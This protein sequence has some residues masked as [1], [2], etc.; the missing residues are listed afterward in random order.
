VI[1]LNAADFA[2]EFPQSHELLGK[3]RFAAVC[4]LSYF[5]GMVCPGLHSMF[6]SLRFDLKDPSQGNGSLA[7]VV[8]RYDRRVGLFEISFHGCIEGALKAFIRPPS[9]LQPSLAEL[10]RHVVAE[11]FRGSRSLIIGGSRGLGEITAK[12]LAAGGGDVIV[13]YASGAEDARMVCDEINSAGK[14][15]C[16]TVKFDLTVDTP[17]SM[18]VDCST[19][20]A[21]Y[22][23]ATPRIFRKKAATFMPSLFQ[24]FSTFYVEKFHEL[25]AHLQAAAGT[26]T[27]R[28]FFPSSIAVAERPRGMTEYSMA[29]AAAEILIQDINRAYGNVSVTCARLPRLNTDQT[30]TL[31][32]VASESNLA[33]MMP[34][35]RSMQGRAT[36]G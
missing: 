11:E 9:Q 19:L 28:V 10:E 6:S 35:I 32:K 16:E 12:V 18:D 13:S 5:V 4:A 25:C 30:A 21:V 17:G 2:A 15:R 14:G 31:L 7:F 36:P 34:I 1:Q 26:R 24:E 3:E 8:R 27:I 23:F 20:D 22:F 29:K 33:T